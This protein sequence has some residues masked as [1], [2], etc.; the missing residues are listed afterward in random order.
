MKMEFNEKGELILEEVYNTLVLKTSE[1]DAIIICMQ[2]DII[3]INVISK[4]N[5]YNRWHAVDMETSSIYPTK[6]NKKKGQ[7]IIA[8][9]EK[10]N[11]VYKLY[12]GSKLIAGCPMSEHDFYLDQK[13][14]EKIPDTNREGY[15]VIYPGGYTSW[16][17]KEP[18]EDSYREILDS[19]KVLF[20]EVKGHDSI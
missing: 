9:A 7:S 3:D 4:N 14:K 15:K 18:F 2:D 1:G 5:A 13:S 19:E 12:I 11:G 8:V 16:S 17:P 6:R 20:S 10:D